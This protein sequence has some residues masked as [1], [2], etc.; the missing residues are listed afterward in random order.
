MKHPR[1]KVKATGKRTRHLK[2]ED[3][4]QIEVRRR[5]NVWEWWSEKGIIRIRT[6]GGMAETFDKCQHE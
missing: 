2:H 1:V 5:G 3:G 6:L 4:R